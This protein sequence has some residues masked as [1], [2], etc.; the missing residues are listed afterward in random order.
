MVFGT[1]ESL[2]K[3]EPNDRTRISQF[4]GIHFNLEYQLG[5]GAADNM[6]YIINPNAI[7]ISRNNYG[8]NS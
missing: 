8:N 6:E 4:I 1:R 5:Q 3:I 2:K 7:F